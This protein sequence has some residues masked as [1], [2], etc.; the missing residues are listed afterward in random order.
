L[1]SAG[2][3]SLATA[4]LILR[5]ARIYLIGP[6]LPGLGARCRRST[7]AKVEQP[8][9]PAATA[10]GAGAEHSRRDGRQLQGGE[11]GGSKGKS[12]PVSDI[13]GFK[14]VALK[15]PV[16]AK[17][18]EGAQGELSELYRTAG[19]GRVPHRG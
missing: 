16:R 15:P 18:P 1:A 7:K 19:P 11:F 17:T 8:A 9:W 4:N 13:H 12:R 10:R 3:G 2:G 5:R 6:E 14:F